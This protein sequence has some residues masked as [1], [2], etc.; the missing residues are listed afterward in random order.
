MSPGSS[1]ALRQVR[2]A[3]VRSP[4]PR[5]MRS[6]W[7]VSLAGRLMGCGVLAGMMMAG[8]VSLAAR[9]LDDVTASKELRVILYDDNEP[10]SWLDNGTVRGIDA[11]IARALAAKLGVEAKFDMRVQGERLDQDLRSN[12]L[13][14]TFGG[15][16]V[17]DVMMHVPVD[18]DY[19]Q[20]R[21]ADVVVSNPYFT[22][23]VA[24]GVAAGGPKA[25][26]SF[27]VF[28]TDKVAVQLGTVADY[29]LMRFQGGALVDNVVHYV[30]PSQGV[31]KLVAGDATAVLGVQSSLE[32][33]LKPHAVALGL[34]WSTPPMPGLAKAS[35]QLGMGFADRSRDLSYALG[36][37]LE[38][39]RAA[40]TVQEITASYGVSYIAPAIQ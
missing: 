31:K 23:R 10:F 20:G 16:A 21:I 29:F 27:E 38:A 9:P 19:I 11:D 1:G 8:A 15:G 30:R 13:R 5:R 24:L 12:L 4:M 39:L 25:V 26:D 33:L 34:R 22:Q 36:N 14:G 28:K 17:G 3:A 18:R 37:A 2:Q 35:W 6:R 40:G 7:P 32:A